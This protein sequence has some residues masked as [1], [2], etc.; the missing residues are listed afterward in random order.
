[1]RLQ[2]KPLFFGIAV[3]FSTA[4][5]SLE[6]AKK[7][8]DGKD[9]LL[10]YGPFEHGDSQ[11][12]SRAVHQAGR[13]D[14]IW[15]DSPG[16]IVTEG[17][18]IGREIHAS[19]LATRIPRGAKCNSICTFAF[20]GGVVRDI[21]PNTKYGVHMFSAWCDEERGKA[22]FM[23]I[24]ELIKRYGCTLK[25][26]ATLAGSIIDLIQEQEKNSALTAKMQVDYLLEMQ[27]SLRFLLPNY[28]KGQACAETY[29]L[30]RQQLK[31]F[32]VI[33]TID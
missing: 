13:I 20:L 10:L 5:H 16:G 8:I 26:V 15:F 21:D 4:S 25:G 6:F 24:V 18:K 12:F 22:L 31:S 11:S 30:S 7:H 29:N 27:V 33:N 1:M 14:E 17:L 28:E 3:L 32:N 2:I 23:A 9:I 19:N